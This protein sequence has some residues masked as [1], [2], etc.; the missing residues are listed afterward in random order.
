MKQ[1]IRHWQQRWRLPELRLLMLALIIS[2]TV[3]TAV[4]F[5]S[6]RVEN[7]MQAQAR[8][9]LDAHRLWRAPEH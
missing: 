6:S 7:A 8:M 5:F 2:V 9:L 3:I 4:G 1:A